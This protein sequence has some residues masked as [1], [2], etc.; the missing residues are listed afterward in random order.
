MGKI[1]LLKSNYSL[2]SVGYHGAGLGPGRPGS[3]AFPCAG[4]AGSGAARQ[5][6]RDGMLRSM[7]RVL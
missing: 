6:V 7:L 3:L 1:I 4:S 2:P 5:P